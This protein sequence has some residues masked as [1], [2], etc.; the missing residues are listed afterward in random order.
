MS[1]TTN[2]CKPKIII[3]NPCKKCIVQACCSQPCNDRGD[4]IWLRER[5]RSKL[6]KLKQMPKKIA[7]GIYDHFKL[8]YSGEP[9]IVRV[10]MTMMY[11]L[12]TVEILLIYFS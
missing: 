1:E 2:Q 9:F 6:N 4:Y 10:L 3:F 11:I 5:T 7:K 8:M 12:V